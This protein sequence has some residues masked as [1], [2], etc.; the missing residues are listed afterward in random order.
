MTGFSGPTGR[1]IGIP[2]SIAVLLY[3]AH[4]AAH[5]VTTGL[6]PVYD[7]IAHLFLSPED[8]IPALAVALY[9]GLRGSAAGRRA[10]FVLPMA[11]L[12]GGLM[13][14]AVNPPPP[15]PV[16]VLS[17]LVIGALVAADMRVPES[18][19]MGLILALGLIHGFLNGI[20]LHGGPGLV[21]LAGIA[22]ALFVLVSLAS[23]LVVSLRR[24][25]TRVVVRVAGSWVAAIGLLMLGWA[26]R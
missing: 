19:V 2:A 5:L 20:A 3:P 4:A 8:L 9:A 11:W 12:V 7:G 16:P 1:L 26:M 21:G 23:A 18:A 17:F 24:P 13:G 14:Y 6:G 25:W 10:M 22:A 15:F